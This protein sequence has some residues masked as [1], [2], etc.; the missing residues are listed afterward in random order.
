MP[1]R[2]CASSCSRASTRAASS[3]T[4]TTRA[5]RRAS[6][7]PPA[8]RARRALEAAAAP[9]APRG[10]GRGAQRRGVR[11][12][13]RHPVTRLPARRL[14]AHAG[15][16]SSLTASGSKPSA[17]ARHELPA[18]VPRPPHWGGYRLLP[19]VIE[20]WRGPAE[21]PARPRAVHAGLG[22]RW[23]ARRLCTVSRPTTMKATPVDLQDARLL[24]EQGRAED[25]GATLGQDRRGHRRGGTDAGSS[26]PTPR[27]RERLQPASGRG[28]RSSAPSRP[29]DSETTVATTD[30]VDRR[31][32][33]RRR[34]ITCTQDEQV[35]GALE[36]DGDA[37]QRAATRSSP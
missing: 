1:R 23:H 10:Q 18:D 24:S 35:G 11:R 26:Q 7:P 14:G 33:G 5:A 6:W 27:G 21:P 30:L 9:G 13:L 4:P 8:R 2:R 3:S 12:L 37:E 19:D 34:S 22:R 15:P 17:R 31:A 32:P 16:R 20:F 36:A 29:A 28:A 25:H